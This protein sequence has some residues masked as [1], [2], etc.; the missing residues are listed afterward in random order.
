MESA[1]VN[2]NLIKVCT[3]TLQY[4]CCFLLLNELKIVCQ[5][6]SFKTLSMNIVK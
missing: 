6:F 3:P 2:Q 1:K 4:F 5:H